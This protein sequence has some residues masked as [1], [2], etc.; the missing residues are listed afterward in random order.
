MLTKAVFVI[1]T[2]FQADMPL[3]AKVVP[4]RYLG[5]II[6]LHEYSFFIF[7]APRGVISTVLL[8]TIA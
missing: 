6:R 1:I 2:V 3:R 4:P 7:F 8:N 5:K